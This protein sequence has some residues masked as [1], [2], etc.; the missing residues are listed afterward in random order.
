MARA[1]RLDKLRDLA[2]LYADQRPGGST[3][4]VPDV[5]TTGFAGVNDLVNLAL[6]ELYD[7][8]VAARGPE[9]YATT[10][11]VSIVNGTAS[12]ALPATFYQ[13]QGL[14]LEWGTNDHE[15][16]DDIARILDRVPFVNDAIWSPWSPK[17]YRLRGLNIELVPTPNASVTGR[18]Y[19][20]PAFVD[21]TSDSQTFDGV[22]G[23]E[24][25][26]ALRVAMELRAIEEMPYGDLEKLYE[27]ER[28][29]IET[30]KTEREASQPKRVINVY[31]ERVQA[32]PMA[33]RPMP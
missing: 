21:L 4:F 25:L 30:M 9:Y 28:A 1:V 14:V 2:R 19:F 3:A 23:W 11:T 10:S 20:V 33:R 12:Y 26:V 27:R 15:P 16:V 6:T 18:L 13:M 24:K 7:L 8:L 5:A 22:N 17:A 32:W 29:R 31:P